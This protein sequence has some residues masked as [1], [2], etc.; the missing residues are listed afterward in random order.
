MRIRRCAMPLPNPCGKSRERAAIR[1]A[2]DSALPERALHGAAHLLLGLGI[3]RCKIGREKI[4]PLVALEGDD[5]LGHILLAHA[6][7]EREALRW[8][9]ADFEGLDRRLQMPALHAT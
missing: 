2:N 6:A 4:D 8:H 1:S 7:R 5:F 9:A 3:A